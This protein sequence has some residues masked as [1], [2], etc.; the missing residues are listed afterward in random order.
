[1]T[2]FSA[3]YDGTCTVCD[4]PYYEDDPITRDSDDSGWCHA[5]CADG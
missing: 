4:E 2:T 3:M 1:M 5:E